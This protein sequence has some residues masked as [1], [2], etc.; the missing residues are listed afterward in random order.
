[1]HKSLDSGKPG[2]EI[3]FGSKEKW[4]LW[5]LLSPWETFVQ[6]TKPPL[7]ISY[8]WNSS[9]TKV[10][11]GVTCKENYPARPCLSDW[12]W[13]TKSRHSE[14]PKLYSDGL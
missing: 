13:V 12:N 9:L 7:S 11:A 6:I 8:Y 1:M 5:S 2:E 14:T 3:C 4:V 10:K